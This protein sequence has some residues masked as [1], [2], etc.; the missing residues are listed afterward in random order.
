MLGWEYRK[1]ERAPPACPYKPA[2]KQDNNTNK[3]SQL[4]FMFYSFMCLIFF[5]AKILIHD[6]PLIDPI[7][8]NHIIFLAIFYLDF[9]FISVNSY[10][11]IC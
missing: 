9:V 2:A 3:V 10:M 11:T 6:H 7:K 8:K 5:F 4:D 1:P